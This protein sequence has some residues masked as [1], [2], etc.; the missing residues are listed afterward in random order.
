[1]VCQQCMKKIEKIENLATPEFTKG[2]SLNN[3]SSASNRKVNQN[4][5]L[6]KRKHVFDPTANKCLRC[7]GRVED[8]NKYC[9]TCAYTKG[10]CEMCGTKVADTKLYKFT[11]VDPKDAKRKKRMVIKTKEISEQILKEKNM[12]HLKEGDKRKVEEKKKE[13][14]VG[15]KIINLS[16]PEINENE[17]EID[18]MQNLENKEEAEED[19]YDEII[20]I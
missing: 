3:L 13:I 15:K 8:K 5:I 17:E 18:F 12:I 9:L 19:E 16:Q 14:L 10:L 11:D 6:N 2:S 1:M 4:M 20:K 7:N